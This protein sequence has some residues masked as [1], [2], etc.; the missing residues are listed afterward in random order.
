MPDT[1]QSAGLTD[2]LMK[3]KGVMYFRKRQLKQGD[4]AVTPTVLQN[5]GDRFRQ[6]IFED[7]FCFFELQVN[8]IGR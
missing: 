4:P 6:L 2:Y 1:G 7:W 8:F 3:L 5:I